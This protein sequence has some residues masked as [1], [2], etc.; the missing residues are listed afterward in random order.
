MLLSPPPPPA[1]FAGEPGREPLGSPGTDTLIWL[2]RHGRVTAPTTAYGDDDVPLSEDG[3]GQTVTAAETLANLTG[4]QSVVASPLIRARTLGERLSERARVPLTLDD[5]LKELHRGGWQGI[6]R[7]E[8][9]ARWREDSDAY[10]GDP[11]NWKRHGGESEGDLVERAW[12]ALLDAIE[13]SPHGGHV[14]GRCVVI[15]AHRQVLR[16]L[17]A[18]AIGIPPGRSHSM[19]LDPAHGILIQDTPG[20]WTLLRTNIF[21]P[22]SRHATEPED[23]PPQDV[24]VR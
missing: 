1:G 11:M 12:P 6:E 15:A 22:G 21:P 19:R 7:T 9:Q 4:L 3:L 24:L 16:A 10:W 5:R 13:K 17:T 20:A 23:G 18:A 8:Y 2:V 14:P